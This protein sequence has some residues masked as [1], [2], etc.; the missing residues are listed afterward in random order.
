M[1]KAI[2]E[3]APIL[4]SNGD[5]DD[6]KWGTS[7]ILPAYRP[8]RRPKWEPRRDRRDAG[9]KRHP[10]FNAHDWGNPVLQAAADLGQVRIAF[11]YRSTSGSFAA[12]SEKSRRQ[13]FMEG[14]HELA[15][16]KFWE[17]SPSVLDFQLQP[18]MISWPNKVGRPRYF[19]DAGYERDDGRLFF[20]EIKAS[21]AFFDEVE[22][23]ELHCAAEAALAPLGVTFERNSGAERWN[24]REWR[25]AFVNEIYASRR[26]LFTQAEADRVEDYVLANG[27][28]APLGRVLETLNLHHGDARAKLYAM[29]TRRLADVSLDRPESM[30]SAVTIPGRSRQPSALRA[31]LQQFAGNAY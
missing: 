8:T 12:Y 22:A 5:A 4:Q 27:G 21:G 29:M 19:I 25:Q 1:A 18:L 20:P 16:F 23:R 7:P 24:Q 3:G 10:R 28:I 11:T 14:P 9:H 26:V 17:V 30:D 13:M 31:F 6:S 15:D 2:I